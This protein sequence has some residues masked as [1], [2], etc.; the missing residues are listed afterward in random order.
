M[1]VAKKSE[2]RV[3]G[4]PMARAGYKG[5]PK[6]LLDKFWTGK[7]NPEFTGEKPKKDSLIGP[8]S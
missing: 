7:L 4:L 2:Y 1:G 8:L 3:E 6:S 5:E